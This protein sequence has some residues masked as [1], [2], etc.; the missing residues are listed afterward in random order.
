[1]GNLKR[2]LPIFKTVENKCAA[3]VSAAIRQ[4]RL[5][6]DQLEQIK[7]YRDEYRQVRPE[8]PVLLA[9]AH[10]FVQRLDESIEDTTQRIKTQ[11]DVV[12]SE[13]EKYNTA[14]SRYKVVEKLMHKANEKNVCNQND[15]IVC[16]QN[17]CR[18]INDS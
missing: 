5:L 10:A 6:E 3:N 18:Q 8:L 15:Q 12:L 14:K 11:N 17:H 9:N 13:I 7:E 1:M 4:K 2:L 16:W